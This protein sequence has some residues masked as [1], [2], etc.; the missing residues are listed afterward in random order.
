MGVK[1]SVYGVNILARANLGTPKM[2]GLQPGVM[3]AYLK[4]RRD[5]EFLM[6]F[7][8]CKVYLSNLTYVLINCML[9]VQVK[10]VHAIGLHVALAFYYIQIFRRKA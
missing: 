6:L 3:S 9:I 10:Q 5:S 4:T 7:G 1:K 2:Y 8:N